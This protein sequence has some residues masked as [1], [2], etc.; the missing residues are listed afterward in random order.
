M[1]IY[2]SSN[3][4]TVLHGLGLSSEVKSDEE[5]VANYTTIAGTGFL[6][7]VKLLLTILCAFIYLVL[8]L[9]MLNRTIPLICL[10]I[11]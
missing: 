5:A 2:I 4:E 6:D 1:E 9:C 3:L 7:I 8:E 10:E 11:Q